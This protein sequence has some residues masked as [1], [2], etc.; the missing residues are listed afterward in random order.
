MKGRS[1]IAA[2]V[3]WTFDE[4]GFELTVSNPAAFNRATDLNAPA[5]SP[6]TEGGSPR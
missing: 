3:A 6:R 2:C 4:E 5:E 1:L